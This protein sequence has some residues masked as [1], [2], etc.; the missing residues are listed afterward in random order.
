MQTEQLNGQLSL[1]NIDPLQNREFTVRKRDGRIVS[2]DE[3]RVFLAIESAFKADAD[4]TRDQTLDEST[5]GVVLRIASQAVNAIIRRA[6][7]GESLEIELL[8]DCVETELMASGRQQVA[9]RYILYREERRR[10]RAL[11]GDRTIDGQ[12]QAQLSVTHLDGSR[13][14]LDVQQI[15]REVIHACRG[16]EGE[17]SWKAVADEAL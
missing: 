12:L 9:R 16:F 3:T 17:C 5:Q 13:E 7:R 15:R 10:E 1:A 6:V 14:P 11:R 2:F 4:L 8:Q